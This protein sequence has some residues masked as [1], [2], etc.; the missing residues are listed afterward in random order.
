MFEELVIDAGGQVVNPSFRDYHVPAFP[1]V[2]FTEVYFADTRDPNGP[3]GAKS[4]SES[5][6]NPVAAALGNALR[7]A[8]GI[9]FRAT[10]FRADR[11]Y[12]RL[13]EGASQ[14]RGGSAQ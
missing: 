4:M 5:P 1:D 11:V 2:P 12:L 6:Y 13:A 9:R 8:T 10:P 3:F 7:D 14:S